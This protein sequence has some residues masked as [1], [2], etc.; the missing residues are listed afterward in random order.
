MDRNS[1]RAFTDNSGELVAQLHNSER[2]DEALARTTKACV[3][4][5]NSIGPPTGADLLRASLANERIG[6][7][8][9][10]VERLETR[11]VQTESRLL[12]AEKR[13][14]Q[15]ETCL[16]MV[17]VAL[18][19]LNDPYGFGESVDDRIGVVDDEAP[20]YRDWDGPNDD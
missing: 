15:H 2:I 18:K 17:A 6:T 20:S 4:D 7:L 11:L 5:A 16:R 10:L 14:A 19:E 1:E 3:N 9:Q 13:V 8:T 12:D